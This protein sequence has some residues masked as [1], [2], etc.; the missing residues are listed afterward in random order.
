M[1][2]GADTPKA[3]AG[4]LDPAVRATAE[5]RSKIETTAHQLAIRFT[6]DADLPARLRKASGS[7]DRPAAK[8]DSEVQ[9]RF[10]SD[11]KAW[12]QLI[13]HMMDAV[14]FPQACRFIRV[15]PEIDS[16]VS[17]VSQ[18]KDFCDLVDYLARRRDKEECSAE[19]LGRLSN[20]AAALQRE[21]EG[22]LGSSYTAA[23]RGSRSGKAT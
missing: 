19:E 8:M 4:S 11:V 9:R 12:V 7:T 2:E 23:T 18:C 22:R 14:A 16:R 21:V 17:R 13:D 20:L 15:A 1:S 6:D 10:D 3:P 5:W